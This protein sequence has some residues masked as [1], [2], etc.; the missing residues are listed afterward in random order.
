MFGSLFKGWAQKRYRREAET[1]IRH[2]RA[3]SDADAG[4][5]LAIAAHHRN[6][7]AETGVA[8]DDLAALAQAKPMYQHE[9][10]K[11]VNVLTREGRQH[12]AIALQVWVHSLRA[13][14]DPALRD[15]GVAL[16][17]QLARG[18]KQV[19]AGRDAVRRETGFDLDI[20]NTETPSLFGA[21]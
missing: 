1:L 20:R 6:K 7:L 3:L 19:E 10:A 2:L 16:W 15:V 18:R 11:A 14:A 17:A 21:P 13:A 12:D 9:L 8:I 5:V 4:L